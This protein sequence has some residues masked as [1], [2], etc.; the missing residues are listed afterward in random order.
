MGLGVIFVYGSY[1]SPKQNL[2]KSTKSIVLLDTLV[3][4][5]SGLIIIPA[6][7]A[8]NLEANAGPTL[9]FIT[10]PLVFGQISGGT[11]FMF[12]FF[13][14]LFI[15]ALTSLISIYEPPVNLLIEKTKMSRLC[16][17][18]L[19]GMLNILG[20]VWVLLSF[21]KVMDIQVAN[22]DLFNF[23]DM[24]TGTFTMTFMVLFISLFMGWGISTILVKNLSSHEKQVSKPFKR[25]LRF[26][27]RF[28]APA[29]LILLLVNGVLSLLDK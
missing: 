21:T 4:F 15:A 19:V 1:L 29:V 25:Y 16:A 27:L 3:A 11:F 10:L 28:T 7:F 2:L 14:L 9:T 8:F 6:V 20:T 13:V 5:I 18:I 17:V 12:L 26:T 23:F 24:L 22:Q